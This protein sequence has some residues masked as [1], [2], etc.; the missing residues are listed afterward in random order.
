MPSYNPSLGV[1]V[2]SYDLESKHRTLI[3]RMTGMEN[4]YA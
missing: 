1:C 2:G 3:I 4:V